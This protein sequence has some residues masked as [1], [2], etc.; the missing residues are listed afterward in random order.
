[1]TTTLKKVLLTLAIA[2]PIAASAVAATGWMATRPVGA[3]RVA[4]AFSEV[5]PQTLRNVVSA[6]LEGGFFRVDVEAVRKAALSLPWIREA[7]VRRVWPDSIHIAVVEREAMARWNDVGL[8]E[9]DGSLFSPTRAREEQLPQLI[10]PPGEHVKVLTT[11]KRLIETLG[12]FG[13]GLKRVSLLARG[14]WELQF[15]H[16]LRLIPGVP[17]DVTMVERM[18]GMLPGLLGEQ[19]SQVSVIDLRYPNGFAVRW[20]DDVD[21]ALGVNRVVSK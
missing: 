18:V 11:Y 2:L 10:G 5:S 6:A 20:R 12:E 13:G 17:L 9:S 21:L 19:L 3:V 7:T 14:E 4:G 16:G 15:A 1:M 8:L